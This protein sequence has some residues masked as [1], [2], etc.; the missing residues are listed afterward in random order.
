MVLMSKSDTGGAWKTLETAPDG[1][2]TPPP[3]FRSISL[4]SATSVSAL[5]SILWLLMGCSPQDAAMACADCNGHGQCEG[6]QCVCET[7]YEGDRCERCAHGH[8][9]V[10]G[11]CVA[12]FCVDSTDCND[13]NP[14]NGRETCGTDR[15]CEAGAPVDCGLQ[16]RCDPSDGAC[17]CDPGW[18]GDQCEDCATGHVMVEGSCEPGTCLTDE[19]C[20]DGDPCN[21][22]ETCGEGRACQPGL[23]M[24]CGD[25]GTCDSEAGGCVCDAGYTGEQCDACAQGY[26][27]VSG[28]CLPV[29]CIADVDCSDGKLCNGQETCSAEH[30]CMPGTAISCGANSHCEEPAADCVCDHGYE[31]QGGACIAVLCDVPQ[32]PTLSIVHANA[33]LSFVAPGHPTVEVGLSADP[34]ALVPS[35]WMSGPSLG[36]PSGGLPYE[37]K[38]FARLDGTACT[39]SSWFSFVYRVQE[40]YPPAAGL[41]GTTAVSMNDPRIVGWA[42]GWQDP[43]TYGAGVDDIWRVPERAVGPAEGTTAGVVSLGEGGSIVLTFDP[44]IS[45]AA[46]ADL[47]VF[48]NAF[49]DTFLELGYVEV[50]SNGLD[51][52]RFDNAYLGAGSVG[53]FSAHEA[54]DIGSL[55]GKYGQG[56]GTPFDLAVFVNRSQVRSG[57]V[58]LSKIRYVRIVDIVGDGSSLDS[59]G[60]PIFDPYPTVGSAGFDLD[61]I[62]VLNQ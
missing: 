47:A 60:R 59:F 44:P 7:G 25:Y 35:A 14:C 17:V 33:V 38:V 46:G 8:V 45:D 12:G 39:Q 11:E 55:A 56:F 5:L 15:V 13:G 20:S 43:V 4:T 42:T 41:P 19:D 51:Y 34:H 23:A 53:G 29:S 31:W 52:L 49:N 30:G 40:K 6:E 32:A 36:L 58:D 37:A 1:F 21:G 9:R 27:M 61:G 26:G 54:Q 57:L 62:A 16:G 24:E 10:D 2:P 18:T 28:Q 3:T 22:Q 48:E 50:S